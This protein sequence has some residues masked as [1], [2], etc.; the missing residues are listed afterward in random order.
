MQ[1]LKFVRW[2]LFCVLTWILGL[3]SKQLRLL[4]GRVGD[5]TT[6]VNSLSPKMRLAGWGCCCFLLRWRNWTFWA[7]QEWAPEICL[8]KVWI[9]Q[10]LT[11]SM[12]L[13][14]FGNEL[15]NRGPNTVI[16]FSWRNF[17]GFLFLWYWITH[18]VP[19]LGYFV[20]HCTINISHLYLLNIY[21]YIT[22]TASGEHNL[23]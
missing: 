19:C 23:S 15:Y 2:L 18:C 14:Y 3:V 17:A 7:H 5:S 9:F 16:A 4:R 10:F 21:N 22:F 6:L 1:G 20:S 8:A 11:L 12:S 13:R